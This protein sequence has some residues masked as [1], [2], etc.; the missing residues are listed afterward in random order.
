MSNLRQELSASVLKSANVF[1]PTSLSGRHK[2]EQILLVSV[3]MV[4]DYCACECRFKIC[5]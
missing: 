2:T 3:Y 5:N 1:P 4:A